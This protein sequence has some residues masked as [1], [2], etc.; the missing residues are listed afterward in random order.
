MVAYN[1]FVANNK[2]WVMC[3]SWSA[4]IVGDV[5]EL[6]QPTKCVGTTNM[7]LHCRKEKF[8]TA[9]RASPSK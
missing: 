9:E 1:R 6:K 8:I 2:M 3:S 5:N 7:L 4:S